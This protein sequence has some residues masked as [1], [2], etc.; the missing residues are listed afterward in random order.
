MIEKTLTNKTLK[1]IMA[2]YLLLIFLF[3]RSFLGIYVLGYRIGELSIL[4]SAVIFFLFIVSHLLKLEIPNFEL[5]N[6]IYTISILITLF[7]IFNTIFSNSSFLNSYTYKASSYIWALGFFFF[8]YIYFSYNQLSA[9]VINLLPLILGYLYMV[10]IY[11]LPIEFQE[12]ILGI[13]DKYEP[14]KGSDLVIFFVTIFYIF[15]RMNSDKR[16]TLEVFS[17]LSALYIPLLLFKSRAG[18]ISICIFVI[19]ELF[20]MKKLFRRHLIRNILLGVIVILI[21]IQSTFLISKSGFIKFEKTRESVSYVTDY[22]IPEQKEGEY[23]ELFFIKDERIFSSDVNLNWRLQ[24]WQDVILD[25]SSKNSHLT[26]YGYDEIIPAMSALDFE[27][28]SVRSGL[29]GLNENVHN[30]F[31]NMYAR[32][33]LVHL[34]MYLFL[35]Y[36]F[37]KRGT[38]KI[39]FRNTLVFLIP[40]L[41]TSSFDASMENSHY[42]L[43]FYFLIGFSFHIEAQTQKNI[44]K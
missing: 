23:F 29:D 9:K 28:N 40:L 18:A 4:I 3:T 5:D 37:S 20:I 25:I 38:E 6:K 16:Y 17:L 32:G 44:K 41:I 7:F 19:F 24:I 8:G 34:S 1:F 31:I 30:F 11:D 22:R 10:S 36:R 15:N 27:G 39:D 26:G 2:T 14:Q 12:F 21:S 13:S 33:G 42:P 43:L 35:L